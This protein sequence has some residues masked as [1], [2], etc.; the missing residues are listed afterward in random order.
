MQ[1]IMIEKIRAG[2]YEIVCGK[3]DK[4]RVREALE[5]VKIFNHIDMFGEDSTGIDISFQ[6]FASSRLEGNELEDGIEKIKKKLEIDG[7]YVPKRL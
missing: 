7:V 6:V 1:K 3:E 4:D 2:Q 5:E